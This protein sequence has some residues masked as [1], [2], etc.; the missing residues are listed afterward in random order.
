MPSTGVERL[1]RAIDRNDIDTVKDLMTSDPALH[2]APLGYGKNGPLTCVAECR[3]PWEPASSARLAIARWMLDNGSDVHQGGDGP[4]MR[5]ALNGDRVPMMELLVAHGADVNA[6]WNG[7]FPIIFASCESVD[8]VAL[9]WL[10]EHGA[11]PNCSRPGRDSTAL[12][13]LICGYV[14]SP[15]ITNCIDLLISAGATSRYTLPGVIK[16]IQDRAEPLARA[17]DAHPDLVHR[18]FPELDCGSTGAR[19]LLLQGAT[20]LHVA[21]EFGS[22]D[23]AALLLRR[24]AEVNARADVDAAGVGGQ[25]PLFHAVTQFDDRG[26]AMTRLLLEQ[27]ADLSLRVKLPGHYERLDEVMESTPL[28][29][30]RLFPGD[31]APGSNAKTIRLLTPRR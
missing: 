24:G 6:E 29:Y 7:N 14:R 16:T 10:L 27:G 4:L 25:T 1:K 26:L 2:R 5:A 23:A 12:D 30:A 28:E 22:T 15:Q 8:P 20:L 3:V 17:L 31:E 9:A 18:R 11:N 19:R 13:Y 21:A